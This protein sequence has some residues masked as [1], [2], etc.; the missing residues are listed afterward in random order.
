MR[1]LLLTDELAY[2][3][4]GGLLAV[5]RVDGDASSEELRALREVGDELSG[6]VRYDNE[7]LLFFST[8]TPRSL[9]QAVHDAG[10][11]GPFRGQA[12]SAPHVIAHEFLLAAIRVA[13]ADG[14]LNEDE[15]RLIR[16]FARE[17][18]VSAHQLE[19]L[20]E[21]LDEG[22]TGTDY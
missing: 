6:G 2:A 3:L 5:C 11:A 8:V 18:H 20:N 16:R 13:R 12:V 15:T 21:S 1:N 17:L 19:H 9:A 10:R 22:D 7:W 14:A 4:L